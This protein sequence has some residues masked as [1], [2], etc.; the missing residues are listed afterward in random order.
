MARATDSHGHT[1]PA[2]R[3]PDRRTYMVSHVLPVAVE[4]R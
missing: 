1:Q 3:D 2:Q 4:V